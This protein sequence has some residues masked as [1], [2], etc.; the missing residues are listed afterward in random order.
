MLCWWFA[1]RYVDGLFHVILVVCSTLFGWYVPRYCDGLFHGMLVV[2]S[3]LCWWFVPRYFDGL[4]HFLF[5]SCA[6]LP[7]NI[8]HKTST[9]YSHTRSEWR[10]LTWCALSPTVRASTINLRGGTTELNLRIQRI[11]LMIEACAD[12]IFFLASCMKTPRGD[13]I[14]YRRVA[15]PTI[16]PQTHRSGTIL[17]REQYNTMW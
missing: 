13:C 17:N 8:T 12:C 16:Q 6:S 2:C 3:T 7:C 10:S 15:H 1:P 9:H 14:H 5:F 4:Y 11:T